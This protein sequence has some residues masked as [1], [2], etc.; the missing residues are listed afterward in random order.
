MRCIKQI[1]DVS[2]HQLFMGKPGTG[3]TRVAEIYGR[4]LKELGILSDGAVVVVGASKL[5]GDAVGA[6]Q[7]TVKL[8]D[9]QTTFI[10]NSPTKALSREILDCSVLR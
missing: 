4:L 7:K 3:K 8:P 9:I 5:I 10:S 2:L 6:T 1:L